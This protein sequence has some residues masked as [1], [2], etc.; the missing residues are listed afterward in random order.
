MTSKLSK[1]AAQAIVY[2]TA[3]LF[4]AGN[5]DI[6]LTSGP[7]GKN[8]LFQ[9]IFLKQG[10]MAFPQT[11]RTANSCWNSCFEAECYDWYGLHGIPF[12]D[13]TPRQHFRCLCTQGRCAYFY[14]PKRY[15]TWF[16]KS[17]FWLF[18][19][20]YLINTVP[21]LFSHFLGYKDFRLVVRLRSF[22]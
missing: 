3:I 22:F 6:P 13:D 1:M 9:H 16:S 8:T 10:F 11:T 18:F 21:N 20:I 4:A 12:Y 19:S 2:V 15:R 17:P 14:V 5:C 7:S